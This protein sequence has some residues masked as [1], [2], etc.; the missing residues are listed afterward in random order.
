MLQTFQ[1]NPPT[2]PPSKTRFLLIAAMRHLRPVW[3]GSRGAC[4]RQALRSGNHTLACGASCPRLYSAETL[5][6]PAPDGSRER[7]DALW[8]LRIP[9]AARG[10]ERTA[11]AGP[12]DR[13][14]RTDPAQRRRHREAADTPRVARLPLQQGSSSHARPAGAGRPGPAAGGRGRPASRRS[15]SAP[16]DHRSAARRRRSP[17]GETDHGAAALLSGPTLQT[18]GAPTGRSL[19]GG[20]GDTP[21]GRADARL[22]DDAARCEG[23]TGAAA[24]DRLVGGCDWRLLVEPDRRRPP[25]HRD[26]LRARLFVHPARAGR[27]G[28][29]GERRVAGDDPRRGGA[30]SAPEPT[31]PY[32]PEA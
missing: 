19:A 3:F 11:R 21:S 15:G 17:T 28:G 32:S 18:R 25:G 14:P 24:R 1:T 13:D 30:P 29:A 23:H 10:P 26:R 12:L 9:G 27:Q 7:C 5:P 20:A 6:G 22:R 31:V 2:S 8:I 4:R 16:D